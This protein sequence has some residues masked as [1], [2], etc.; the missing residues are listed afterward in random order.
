[1]V[2]HGKFTLHLV[3]TTAHCTGL[4]HLQS[5]TNKKGE[6]FM[7]LKKAFTFLAVVA[8]I[9]GSFVL[10]TYAASTSE[11]IKAYM[12]Y[13]VSVNYNG[14]NVIMKDANGERV[15][16][17]G[18]QGTTYIPIRAMGNLFG[19][20][21][22]WD[23]TTRTVLLGGS[24]KSEGID[25]IDN[26]KPYAVNYGSKQVPKSEKQTK[27]IGGVEV[28]HWLYMK[29]EIL[30]LAG[31]A[32]GD[33]YAYYNLGGKYN[34]LTFEVAT[35]EDTMLY[36][37]GDNESLLGKVPLTANQTPLKVTI[38]LLETTQLHFQAILSKNSLNTDE[39]TIGI[40]NAYLT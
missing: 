10:G 26:F 32:K 1:M 4:D 7:K 8:A 28:N 35:N 37:Y 21:V 23:G 15:Y 19:I 2:S 16:P 38:P 6:I 39:S 18:Y 31:G 13:D 36:V 40:F 34:N 9:I 22:D 30:D 12:C 33:T 29:N 24:A 20:P 25:L 27:S 11:P 5:N 17:I 3:T 14:E